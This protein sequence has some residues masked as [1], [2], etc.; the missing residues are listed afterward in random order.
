MRVLTV[1]A[2]RR[3][4]AGAVSAFGLLAVLAATS[5]VIAA[6]QAA[7]VRS[8]VIA[9]TVSPTDLQWNGVTPS[10]LQWNGV[11]PNDLQ[12]N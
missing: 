1:H 4:I 7:P 11:T 6:N 10:D 2:T 9:A 5:G 8:G 3:A 12:W